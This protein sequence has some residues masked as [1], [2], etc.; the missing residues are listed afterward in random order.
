MCLPQAEPA[1]GEAGTEFHRALCGGERVRRLPHFEVAD[2]EVRV[3]QVLVG[4]QLGR[5]GRARV[6]GDGRGPVCSFERGGTL[7]LELLHRRLRSPRPSRCLLLRQ[8]RLR[9]RQHRLRRRLY[10]HRR[11]LPRR[12]FLKRGCFSIESFVGLFIFG[13]LFRF[14]GLA[15]PRDGLLRSRARGLERERGAQVGQRVGGELEHLARSGAAEERLDV[16]RVGGDDGV[17]VADDPGVRVQL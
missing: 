9:L 16:P 1:L 3:D 13:G 6:R 7:R 8:H 17:G 11:H 14:G 10:R 5:G 12:R 4:A 15:Q 2:R